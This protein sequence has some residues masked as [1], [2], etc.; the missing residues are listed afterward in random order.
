MD[1]NCRKCLKNKSKDEFYNNRS[2]CK[3]CFKEDL[4]NIAKIIKRK[5]MVKIDIIV[6]K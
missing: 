1:K 4:K 5:L 6:I 3:I 2:I